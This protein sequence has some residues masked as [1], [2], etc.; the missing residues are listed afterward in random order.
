MNRH[1]LFAPA[2]ALSAAVLFA[3]CSGGSP[4]TTPGASVPAG[5]TAAP[6][7][8]APTTAGGQTPGPTLPSYAPDPELATR[9]P[10]TIDGQ[11]VTDIRT[12]KF[13]DVI[14]AFSTSAADIQRLE[15]GMAAVGL[16]LNSLGYG[17]A[18][19]TVDGKTVSLTALRTPNADANKIIQN[20]ALLA[21]LSSPNSPS[22]PSP[23]D[24]SPERT[25]PSRR[26]RTAKR[27]CCMW[28]ATRCSASMGRRTHKRRRSCRRSPNH[29]AGPPWSGPTHR[30]PRVGGPE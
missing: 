25:S 1:I 4:T 7:T 30:Q 20:Y 5:A 29:P 18:T 28:W 22:R 3:A 14:K 2:A 6:A 15:Q 23:S 9:F 17:S 16:D 19:A 24:P 27:R 11:P 8:A 12:F 13:I 21:S 26:T 10:T